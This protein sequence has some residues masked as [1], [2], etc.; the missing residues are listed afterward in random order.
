MTVILIILAAVGAGAAGLYIHRLVKDRRER[1]MSNNEYTAA[2]TSWEFA[3]L[4]KAEI[5]LALRQSNSVLDFT[6]I[7]IPSSA[8]YRLSLE[9]IGAYFRVHAVPDRYARTGRLSFVTDTTL[10]VRSADHLGQSASIEDDEYK[11]ADVS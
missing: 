1:R 9:L 2:V 5:E 7:T 8:G 10:T 11:G 3:K 4:V 6:R